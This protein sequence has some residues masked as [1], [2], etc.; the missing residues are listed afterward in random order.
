[1][2]LDRYLERLAGRRFAFGQHDCLLAVADW[3]REL[4]GHDEGAWYRGTYN[5]DAGWRGIVERA[6]GVVRLLDDTCARLGLVPTLG[7]LRCG[8]VGAIDLPAGVGLTGAIFVGPRWVSVATTG[9]AS[10][11]VSAARVATAWGVR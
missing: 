6:G 1:M 9:L 8:D 2:T 10:L 7:D 5:T 4:T 3:V 11:S